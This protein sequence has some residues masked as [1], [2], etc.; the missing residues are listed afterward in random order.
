[1]A[2]TAEPLRKAFGKM[3]NRGP[4]SLAVR[5]YRQRKL[6]SLR[7]DSIASAVKIVERGD[8]RWYTSEKTSQPWSPGDGASSCTSSLR[9]APPRYV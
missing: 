1:M 9:K 6:K 8:C 3:M 5:V 2:K 7:Y 4:Q